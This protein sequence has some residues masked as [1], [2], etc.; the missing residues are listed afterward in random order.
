MPGSRPVT[1]TRTGAA[2]PTHPV[3]SVLGCTITGTTAVVVTGW[4]VLPGIYLGVVEHRRRKEVP[5]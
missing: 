1:A 2:E 3:L 5:G 4:P